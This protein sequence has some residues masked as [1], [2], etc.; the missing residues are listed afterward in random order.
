MVKLGLWLATTSARAA[1]FY[2]WTNSPAD[3]PG[4]DWTNAFHTIQGAVDVA[5][6]GDTVL[7]TNGLYNAGGRVAPGQGL[8]SRLCVTGAVTILSVN[9]PGNTIISGSSNGLAPG[10]CIS[11]DG[12]GDYVRIEDRSALDLTGDFTVEAWI[13]PDTF[14]NH[15]GI[16]SKYQ[17]G[18]ANGWVLRLN[19]TSPY[20]GIEF[21]EQY[22]TNGVLSAGTWTHVAAVRNGGTNRVFING[23]EQPLAGTPLGLASNSDPVL[24]GCDFL[25]T[26]RYFDGMIDEVR[27]WGQAR[28]KTEIQ[29]NMY[30]PLSGSETSLIACWPFQEAQSATQAYDISSNAFHGVLY[31]NAT[32]SASLLDEE[33]PIRG[34]YLAAG[35]ILNGF[36]VTNGFA[37]ISGGSADDDGGGAYLDQGGIL[38]NCVLTG[39]SAADNGGGLRFHQGGLA[40]RCVIKGNRSSDNG[41]GVFFYQGGELRNSLVINNYAATNSGGLRFSNGGQARNCTVSG[42][43]AGKEAGGIGVYG[44]GTSRNC[45]VYFNTAPSNAN[46]SGGTY[47]YSCL[48]TNPGGTGNITNNPLFVSA[49]TNYHLQSASPCRFAGLAG[50]ARGDF[51]L[52]G[53]PRIVMNSVDMGC[54]QW[55]SPFVEQ[56]NVLL[57]AVEQSSVA[58]GDYDSDGDLDFLLAGLRTG[59]VSYAGLYRNTAESFAYVYSGLP[60]VLEC[61]LAWGDYDNDG[62]LDVL[63]AGYSISLD[64]RLARIY[65]NNAGSFSNIGAPLTGVMACST[66]W[67][68]YDNDGDLDVLLA[69]ETSTGSITHLYRNNAGS[70]TNANAGLP[71]VAF[72]SVA[73]GDYDNDGDL[74][75]LLAGNSATGRISSIYRND[76]GIFTEIG[77]GLVGVSSCSAAWGDYDNDGDLDFLVAGYGAADPIS[78]IFRNEGSVSN[79]PPVAPSGLVATNGTASPSG[80]DMEFRWSG[81]SDS[82][83]PSAGLTYNI[84]IGTNVLGETVLSPMANLTNGWRRVAAMGNVNQATNLKITALSRGRT[85]YWSVQAVDGALAGGAWSG[86]RSITAPDLPSVATYAPSNIHATTVDYG[87]AVISQGGS[88]VTGRGVVWGT[89]ASVSI[90]DCLGWADHGSSTGAF[91]GTLTNL[92]PVQTYYLRAYASNSMGLAYGDLRSFATSNGLSV[93]TFAP[94]NI[95]PETADCLGD[96]ATEDGGPVLSKGFVWHT[97]SSVWVTNRLGITDQGGGTGAFNAT[98]TNLAPAKTYYVKAYASNSYG[99]GYGITRFFTTSNGLASVTTYVPSNVTYESA[100]CGG[101]VTTSAFSPVTAKGLVWNTN[102]TPTVSNYLGKTDYGGGLGAF[103]DTLTNLVPVRTYYVRAY[104]SNHYGVSYGAQYSFLTSNGLPTVSTLPAS[105]VT[106]DSAFSG[107]LL[108]SMGASSQCAAGVLWSTNASPTLT[109]SDGLTAQTLTTTGVFEAQMTGLTP[110]QRYYFRAYATNAYGA[111]YGNVSQIVAR[112]P[113]PGHALTVDGSGDYA[114][115]SDRPVLDLTNNYTIEIWFKPDLLVR[116]GGL[117]S[118]YHSTGANGYLVRLSS[119]A[120]YDGI[121]FDEMTTTNGLVTTGQWH[122]VA[123]VNSNGVRTLYLNGIRRELS[124]T[125]MAVKANADALTIGADYLSSARYFNGQIDEVRLWSRVLSEDEVR[126]SMHRALTGTESNLVAY[127]ACDQMDGTLFWDASGRGNDG[128]LVANAGW[129]NS[130]LPCAVAITNRNNIRGAWLAQSNSLESSILRVSSAVADGR[131]FRVFGHDGGA[132]TNDTADKP[133]NVAWRLNRAWQVEGFGTLAG[134]VVFDCS[135]ITNF[136]GDGMRLKLLSDADGV[137]ADASPVAGVYAPPQFVVAAQSVPTGGYYTLA[138]QWVHTINASAGP[139]GGIAPSGAVEVVNGSDTSFVIAPDGYWHVADVSTNGASVGAVSA[140]TWSNVVADGAIHAEFAADLAAGGTPHWWLAQYGWTSEFDFWETNDTDGDTFFAWEEQIADTIPT[141]S[142][143]FFRLISVR[144]TN[145]CAVAFGC[146]NSRIYTLEANGSLATNHWSWVAGPV[147]GAADGT[148]T[149]TDSVD[150]VH[151]LYRVGVSRP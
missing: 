40:D 35:A 8:F 112:L 24:I 37:R 71:G 151:R 50:S 145:P 54:Y 124:G 81:A 77:A 101:T 45:I 97:N 80:V 7:V 3:G 57:Q 149:L 2:V 31:G 73:W 132:L 130:T 93:T 64:S 19:G 129:T 25:A 11:L 142:N 87:G 26:P 98:L 48:A 23:T 119:T 148:L 82:E 114:S 141:D 75:I 133:A 55:P 138:G 53:G 56:T 76:N 143:S 90:A 9:G 110:G 121:N 51:D 144:R 36:T 21:N 29:A 140:F 52:D 65:R 63:L 34:V 30:S 1:T 72:C 10:R 128:T 147:T 85:Y 123:A 41:G 27:I 105:N 43:N 139:H 99:V 100:Q 12:T 16:V 60:G 134:D 69:G 126:D 78:R 91:G 118:K 38:S 109:V 89:N 86:E 5:A 137:F 62:D 135:D 44:S 74:D 127:Y 146:T 47:A 67:G 104:A 96:V 111:G 33:Q 39:N 136:I 108:S 17:S 20:T 13:K 83:T 117:V 28:S 150:A 70:F 125:P 15:K 79:T 42:N 58:W 103:S 59:D 102:S 32:R 120:P 68:D 94:S 92:T 116:L 106:M 84:R 113:G 6:S 107:G 49:G 115:V 66:A 122:H 14:G 18:G 88:A 95:T 4:T 131:N 61:S 22:T 46:I